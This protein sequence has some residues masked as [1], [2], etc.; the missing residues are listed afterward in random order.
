MVLHKLPSRMQASLPR[1][2]PCTANASGLMHG[3]LLLIGVCQAVQLWGSYPSCDS[4]RCPLEEALS[5]LCMTVTFLL[6]SGQLAPMITSSTFRTP[7]PN[8][9]NLTF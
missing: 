1:A 4:L 9:G 8:E 6:R 5:Q 3:R 7:S 2:K